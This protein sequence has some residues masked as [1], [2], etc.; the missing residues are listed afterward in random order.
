MFCENCG[1]PVPEGARF[2]P[3]CGFPQAVSAPARRFCSACGREIGARDPFCCWCGAPASAM[4][5]AT[6]A[7]QATPV[8]PA[9]Y[10]QSAAMSAPA[11]RMVRVIP[12]SV[13]K[14]IT[15]RRAIGVTRTFS[16]D[17]LLRF[18]H[19]R[20]DTAQYNQLVT[21]PSMSQ[22]TRRYVVLPATERYMII[23]YSDRKNQVVLSYIPSPAGR[24]AM[25][26]RGIPTN[27]LFFG[28]AKI[29]GTMSAKAEREGPLED[30][31]QK[32]ADYLYALLREAGFAQ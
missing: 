12:G 13:P 30:I 27:N 15:G 11:A 28:I 5:A 3:G 29:A 17:E 21:D 23:V 14:K 6:P 22:Y 32:Y 25:L 7:R 19:E 8:S 16:H 24:G 10:T 1:T 31:L 9:V 2:C 18:M 4:T 20:W 26:V